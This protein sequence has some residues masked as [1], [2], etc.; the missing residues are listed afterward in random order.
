V[1][2]RNVSISLILVAL[3]TTAVFAA[4]EDEAI[5]IVK[6][7]R[8]AG[9]YMDVER[10]VEG[11]LIG[12]EAEGHTVQGISWDASETLPGHYDVRYSFLLDATNAEAIFLLD[13]DEGRVSPAND[14]AR[15]AVTIATTVDIGEEA[16]PA[17][18]DVTPGG[19]RTAAHIQAEIKIKQRELEEV[20]EN[21]LTRYP[22]ASGKLKLRFTIMKSGSV[23]NVETVESTINVKVLEV[24]LVRAVGRWTFAPASNDVTL[25]YPFI[26]YSTR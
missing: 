19:E 17:P 12:F 11:L 10:A 25:T 16:P 22:D 1:A 7:W 14:V 20:Y 2:G 8:G 4:G 3:T 6:N 24:A 5:A 9:Y 18:K 26:F 15:A 21:Y 13:K 23:A